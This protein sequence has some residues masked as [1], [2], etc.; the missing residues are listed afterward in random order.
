MFFKTK[1]SKIILVLLLVIF[2]LCIILAGIIYSRYKVKT[3]KGQGD[4]SSIEVTNDDISITVLG[5]HSINDNE[6]I[7]DPIIIGKDRL[8]SHLKAIK[9]LGFITI[10]M[11]DLEDYILHDKEIP[12]KSVLITFDDG[13]LDNYF[14]AYPLLK[15]N[16]M[17]ATIFVISSLLDKEPFMTKKQVKELSENGIDI[18]SH[19]FSHVDLDKK[20]YN[21]QKEE[22]QKS[23]EELEKLLCKNVNAI[24]YP[25]GLYNEDTINAANDAGYD[26]GFTVER[27][28]ALKKKNRF[29]INRVLVDYTYDSNDIRR[30][31]IK[32]LIS[33]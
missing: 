28:Y 17:K 8:E 2:I 26:V 32:S 18:E 5:Y 11:K 7:K 12:R 16:H 3:E 20:S 33:K 29:K 30:V 4:F 13:Y 14:N 23:K 27:G 24:A 31:L 10:S 9:D 25:K 22:L 19:T 6:N 1:K 15:E 21:E